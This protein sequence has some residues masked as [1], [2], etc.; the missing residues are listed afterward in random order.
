MSGDPQVHALNTGSVWRL[1]SKLLHPFNPELGVGIVR[2]V[3]GR[4]LTVYFPLVDREVT[5]AAEG[6]GLRRLVLSAGDSA[7]LESTGEEVR[8][9]K[10]LD[11]RYVLEDGREVDEADVWPQ[12]AADTPVERLA[13]LR[14]DSVDSF[15]NRIAGLELMRIREAGGLGSFLGGRIELFPHQLHTA[16]RAVEADPV[17][18]LLADEVGLGKTVEACLI[19]SALVRTKRAERALVVAPETLAVQWL[20]ELYRKFHQVFVLLDAERLEAVETDYGEGVNPFEVH[21]FAV[22]PL[23]VAAS[24]DRLLAQAAEAGLDVIVIDEAHRLFRSEYTKALS[25]LVRHARHALLLSATPLQ[26]DQKG[27]Y[28][29]ISLLHPKL[30]KSY[31][32]FGDAVQKGDAIIPCASAV[33]RTEVGGLPERIATPVDVA[34]PAAELAADARFSWLV[35]QVSEWAAKGEKCLVFVRDLER[36][37]A[38]VPLLESATRTRVAV[39]HEELSLAKRD[40][41]V[42]AFRESPLPLLMCTEAGGEGRNFQFCHRMLHFDLPRDPVELEQRIGRLDRIG[43]VGPVEIVYFRHPEDAATVAEPDL[44]RLYEKLDLFGRPAAGLDIALAPVAPA[45]AAAADSGKVLAVEKLVSKVEKARSRVPSD[46]HAVFYPDGY[47]AEDAESILEKVPADLGARFQKFCVDAAE[48]LCLECIDKEGT[49]R[50]YFEMESGALVESLP[51]VESDARFLGTFDRA[52][53]VAVEEIDFF[54]SGHPWVEGLLLEL[55][56]G[57]RGRAAMLEVPAGLL[58]VP[59]LACVYKDGPRWQVSVVEADGTPR[60]EWE[61]AFLE[62]VPKARRAKP[63]RKGISRQWADGLRALAKQAQGKGEI[64]AAAFFF[65]DR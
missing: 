8:I 3:E 35:A 11:H 41:E 42:A 4:F 16:M 14:L 28:K 39:F 18:W 17:R 38:L 19:L 25:A 33:R 26:E 32:A 6:A 61:Q 5:L 37:E 44:A 31:K 30:F 43:R 9:A 54:A 64:V 29:L 47:R 22:L 65:P 1:G 7:R 40:I 57:I 12:N 59:G 27:F 56:D 53:A 50:F 51:G 62:A 46:W 58:R 63:E 2:G 10:E 23:D 21:P 13:G 60:P 48:D 24:D 34:A 15:R 49:A 45:I 55:E 52:E 36:L 20:G